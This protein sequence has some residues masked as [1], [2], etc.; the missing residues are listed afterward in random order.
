M[1]AVPTGYRAAVTGTST[2]LGKELLAV[3]NERRFP[4]SR[5]VKF[6]SSAD[7]QVPIID[8][9]AM[10]GGEPPEDNS[11]LAQ[12]EAAASR[13]IEPGELDLV[14]IA[15]PLMDVPPWLHSAV[16]SSPETASTAGPFIIDLIR[17]A[18]ARSDPA[19]A[20]PPSI[21]FI[22]REEPSAGYL[23]VP[24]S[25]KITSPHPAAIVISALLDRLAG[26]GS[27]KAA[28][29]QVFS[30][31]SEVGPGGIEELQKQTMNLLSFQ[32]IPESVFGTQLAFNLLPRLGRSARKSAKP[33]R[34][35]LTDLE[36]IVRSQV[37]QHLAGRVA[38]PALRVF[39]APIFYSLVVSLYA[40]LETRVTAELAV[41]AL[42]SQRIQIRKT[43]E[44]AVSPVAVTGTDQILLD[45]PVIDSDHPNGIW[46]WAAADNFRLAAV[47][48]V[49][50][51]ES[52]LN[53]KASLQ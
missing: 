30:S 14:F 23:P 29:A 2:L 19:S 3:I 32:K 34:D 31:G 50:I 13:Q 40:E 15:G 17:A 20:W 46:I 1:T 26:I 10:T 7:P 36:A 45:P 33:Y 52:V 24:D 47:N 5:L 53:R 11:D 37:R 9:A 43:S 48:A 41:Q 12:F 6:T 25:R 21:P 35:E 42:A 16:G 4:V 38:V 51:A 27:V 8:L 18:S 22:T 49:E 28:V 39:Q 44:A